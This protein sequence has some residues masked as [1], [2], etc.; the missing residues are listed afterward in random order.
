MGRCVVRRFVEIDRLGLVLRRL[1]E[2]AELGEAKEEKSAMPNRKRQA[3]L[4]VWPGAF[5]GQVRRQRRWVVA[6]ELDRLRVFAP[7]VMRPRE[8]EGG[9]LAKR[10]VVET[11]CDLQRTGPE[12]HRFV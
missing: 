1:H 4:S 7:L 5:G 3:S 6:Q 8:M 2:S 11:C 9:G 10:R 12:Y